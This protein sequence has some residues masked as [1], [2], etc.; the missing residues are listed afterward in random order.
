MTPDGRPTPGKVTGK[1]LKRK[2]LKGSTPVT[3][4]WINV[5]QFQGGIHNLREGFVNVRSGRGVK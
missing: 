2:F 1:K 5:I 3:A 4:D